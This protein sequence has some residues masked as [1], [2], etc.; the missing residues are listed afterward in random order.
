[1]ACST[2]AAMRAFCSLFLCTRSSLGF[3]PTS[4]GRSFFL[5][6]RMRIRYCVILV[7][8]CLHL[9]FMYPGQ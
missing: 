5:S 1:M 3:T 9:C 4:L 2:L 6:F 7:R 8:R